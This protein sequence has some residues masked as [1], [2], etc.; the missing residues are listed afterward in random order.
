MTID[1]GFVMHSLLLMNATCDIY[2]LQ[3]NIRVGKGPAR[4][5]CALIT[6]MLKLTIYEQM[7]ILLKVNIA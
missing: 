6:E 3:Y 2:F 7:S 1:L 5:T 4:G